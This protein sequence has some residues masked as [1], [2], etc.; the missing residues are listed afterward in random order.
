MTYSKKCLNS[1]C[2]LVLL[3]TAL[4]LY[5]THAEP[6]NRG[7]AARS[8]QEQ[9]IMLVEKDQK[10][11]LRDNSVVYA[12]IFRP[13]DTSKQY[14]VIFT[15][16]PY[17]KEMHFSDFDP[18]TYSQSPVQ[19]QNMVWETPDPETWVKD[20][21]IIVRID[22][23]GS[24]KSPGQV[25]ILSSEFAHDLYDVIEWL[26]T[27]AWSSGKVGML[28][29]SYYAVSQWIAAEMHPPHLAAI[30]P[31]EGFTDAY[32]DAARQ[33]GI[34]SNT[35]LNGW[36]LGRILTNQH[37]KGV[38]DQSSLAQ[39][40]EIPH[41][42]KA[43]A[44]ALLATDPFWTKSFLPSASNLSAI[45][46]PVYSS[47]N[48][49][50]F[51]LHGKGNIEGFQQVSSSH[52]WLQ[53]HTGTFVKSFYGKEGVEDQKRF[54]D[55]FLKNV[56]ND[57]LSIP[58]IKLA[59]RHGSGD[60]YTWR[61]EHEWPLAR[62]QWTPFYLDG[63]T[64]SLST[65][66]HVEVSKSDYDEKTACATFYTAPFAENTEITGPI[67]LKLWVSST[68]TDADLF[69]ALKKFDVHGKEM[70]QVNTTHTP[71]PVTKGWL[72][73]SHRKLDS[74][75]SKPYQPYHSHDATLPLIPGEVVAVDVEV[76]PTSMVF[77][78]GTTLAVVI[79]GTDDPTTDTFFHT[80]SA[81]RASASPSPTTTIWTGS[82]YDSHLLLP[83]IPRS[84][85]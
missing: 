28:G 49:G 27:Q 14:P 8:M 57:M 72:R 37:G 60:Q 55:K 31:W 54:F 77:E 69:V 24:G 47:G 18:K 19:N 53:M 16:G 66:A 59:I 68:A 15:Y 39:N 9:P 63:K 40:L 20:G 71:G 5:L 56:D 1:I 7:G 22:Q 78:V 2:A 29:V 38:T 46:I 10:I 76:W 11:P 85:A 79:S 44:A 51:A 6:N 26:G 83:V 21:Y 43:V 75:R 25:R 81:D 36:Y 12:D 73:V 64:N 41:W 62:T 80:D 33:G 35:F 30:V 13:S 61:Y 48:W 32:R 70:T 3:S 67:K 23:R 34:L 74:T 4:L 65:I 82:N 58:P 50:G 42:P 84:G 52:K 17:C 45:Q